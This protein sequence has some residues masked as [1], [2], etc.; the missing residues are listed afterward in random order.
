MHD[1]SSVKIATMACLPLPD[2]SFVTCVGP[3]SVCRVQRHYNG[4]M[5]HALR[6]PPHNR[7]HNISQVCGSWQ[8]DVASL[9]DIH[10]P[11]WLYLILII[12]IT[13]SANTTK[14][15]RSGCLYFSKLVKIRHSPKGE[16]RF[17][18]RNTAEFCRLAVF[19]IRWKKRKVTVYW[20]CV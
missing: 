19:P 13:T 2:I 16:Q 5:Q 4:H 11:T 17:W 12:K 20:C 18:I 9:L 7:S 8:Q 10:R 1:L 14:A 3:R 6:V 15:Q